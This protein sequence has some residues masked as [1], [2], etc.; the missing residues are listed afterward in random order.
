M[1]EPLF[2]KRCIFAACLLRAFR[3]EC[4]RIHWPR[5]VTICFKSSRESKLPKSA[6]SSFNDPAVSVNLCRKSLQNKDLK[7]QEPF[8]PPAPLASGKPKSAVRT[9]ASR[10]IVNNST[11]DLNLQTEN[12][13]RKD[14]M[15][16]SPFVMFCKQNITPARDDLSKSRRGVKT[17]RKSL[18]GKGI[19]LQT[20]E[21]PF[22][23]EDKKDG[24]N[25]SAVRFDFVEAVLPGC[26]DFRKSPLA[27]KMYNSPFVMFSK[28]NITSAR[29]DL[30]KSRRGK[31]TCSDSGVECIILDSKANDIKNEWRMKK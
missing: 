9:P 4:Y 31:N 22:V 21:E 5:H 19:Q 12:P 10:R 30:S 16:N 15:Y 24:E 17:C 1:L 23:E 14:K 27:Y 7:I 26:G 20:H 18:G 25:I 8:V 6:G 11:S 2:H 3:H 28:Q 13:E 29:D